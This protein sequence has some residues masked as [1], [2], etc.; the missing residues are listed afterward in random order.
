MSSPLW[1]INSNSTK[2]QWQE[3]VGKPEVR[4]PENIAPDLDTALESTTHPCTKKCHTFLGWVISPRW[5]GHLSATAVSRE[6][7]TGKGRQPRRIRTQWEM[8]VTSGH[9]L[10]R[11]YL[12][13]FKKEQCVSMPVALHFSRM[14]KECAWAERDRE[15]VEGDE[16]RFSPGL[17]LICHSQTHMVECSRKKESTV[18]TVEICLW[19]IQHRINLLQGY[20]LEWQYLILKSRKFYG[21]WNTQPGWWR[22]SERCFMNSN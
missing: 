8:A 12:E 5:K 20:I 16:S 13:A 14:S 2:P 4:C 7:D 19:G 6:Q 11:Q 21:L 15:E 10:S 9:D 22:N 1:F 3:G 17:I 18:E